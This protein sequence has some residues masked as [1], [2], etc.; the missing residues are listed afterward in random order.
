V[1]LHLLPGA[2]DSPPGAAQKRASRR[3]QRRAREERRIVRR[4]KRLP[5]ESQ[6]RIHGAITELLAQTPEQSAG[7][8]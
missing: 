8:S 6:E 4:I 2:D 1:V 7:E 3:E 5:R